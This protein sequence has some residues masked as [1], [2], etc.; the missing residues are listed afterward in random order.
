MSI[1]DSSHL[2]AVNQNGMAIMASL[3][4]CSESQDKSTD[5]G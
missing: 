4:E 2:L 1:L 5:I 3:A